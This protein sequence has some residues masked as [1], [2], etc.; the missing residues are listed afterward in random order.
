VPRPVTRR[1][2]L[3]IAVGGAVGT[4]ARAGID[5]ALPHEPG[6][7][8]WPTFVVNLVGSLVLGWVLGR[9]TAP[10]RYWRPLLGT[11]FCGGLTTF[12][13]FAVETFELVRGGHLA[14]AVGYPLASLAAGLMLAVAGVR[15]ARWRAS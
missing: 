1:I 14:L 2:Q 5:E 15:I 8:P 6:R 3:A 7:W 10:N 4:L 13:A 12:S 9:P 11:G